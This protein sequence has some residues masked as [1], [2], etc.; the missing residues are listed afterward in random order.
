MNLHEFLELPPAVRIGVVVMLW[1]AIWAAAL[2]TVAT[3]RDLMRLTRK[4]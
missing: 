2:L 3:A 4:V 1:P